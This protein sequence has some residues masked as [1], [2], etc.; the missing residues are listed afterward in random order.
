MLLKEKVN[1]FINV[2]AIINYNF[3]R[4]RYVRCFVFEILIFKN[5]YS[6]IILYDPDKTIIILLRNSLFLCLLNNKSNWDIDFNHFASQGDKV[7]F[8]VL[9]YCVKLRYGKDFVN[10]YNIILI[11]FKLKIGIYGF[12]LTKITLFLHV[13]M[14]H[15]YKVKETSRREKM[16]IIF[17][18][19][20]R[21]NAD[22]SVDELSRAR[23]ICRC[24][25]KVVELKI[26]NF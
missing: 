11:C 22:K 25:D 12:V 21:S 20:W 6:N 19:N 16:N 5:K 2:F 23:L 7:C 3:L 17:R 1:T 10:F 8:F 26:I 18:E 24:G 14:Y 9:S 4:D 15:L 13:E